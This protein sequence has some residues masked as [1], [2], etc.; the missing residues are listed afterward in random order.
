MMGK[1]EFM[2]LLNV[3]FRADSGESIKFNVSCIMFEL[4]FSQFIILLRIFILVF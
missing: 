2:C 4:N 3:N 1:I